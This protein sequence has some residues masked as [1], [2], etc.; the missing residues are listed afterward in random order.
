MQ[1][2]KGPPR[3]RAVMLTYGSYGT[4]RRRAVRQWPAKT[5][6]AAYSSD[7]VKESELGCL[8]RLF[9][10]TGCLL[11]GGGQ[12]MTLDPAGLRAVPCMA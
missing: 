10:A 5:H 3:A 2:A 12:L 6:K 9:R 8:H 11:L 4:P 7:I 1:Q